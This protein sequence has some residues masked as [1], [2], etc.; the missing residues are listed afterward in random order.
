MK[1]NQTIITVSCL[2][3]TSMVFAQ[4][5]PKVN[6]Y[7]GNST[8]GGD[9]NSQPIIVVSPTPYRSTDY[10]IYPSSK[11]QSEMSIAIS[12]IDPE[13]LLVGANT[14]YS[15]EGNTYYYQGYYYSH[16]G[17]TV[18][19]G[20]D[21][22]PGITSP[23]Y[24][25]AV[26][27]DSNGNVFFHFIT[28]GIGYVKKSTDG[29]VTWQGSIAIP[30][31]G[32][33]DKGHM[34]IDGNNIYVGLTDFAS[35]PG[36][37][38]II[39][40]STD[41]GGTFSNPINISEEITNH[42]SMGVNLA[43]GPNGEVYA[44]WAIGEDW[45]YWVPS[46]HASEGIGFNKSI[47]DG[48]NWQIPNRI[49][50]IDGS[51]NRWFDKNPG[52]QP[53]RTNDFPSIV[54]DRSG[55]ERDGTIYMVWGAKGQ[56]PDRADIFFSKSTNE[57]VS[58]S[59]PV[60]IHDDNTSNDQWF[61]WITVDDLGIIHIVFYDSRNDPNNQL[62]EVWVAQ[63]ID[64]GQSFTNFRV[65]DV[66]FT[67]TPIP[68]TA[69][70]YM[71]DYIGIASRPGKVYT[72]WMDNR[73]GIYQ[74]YVDIIDNTVSGIITENTTW[75]GYKLVTGNVSV[76]D[77]VI[78]TIEPGTSIFFESSTFLIANG[79]LIINGTESNPIVFTSNSAN[80]SVG[81]WQGIIIESGNLEMNY[82]DI[83]YANV[84]VQ[85][86]GA[87][88]GVIQNSHI[89]N[90]NTGIEYVPS[91]FITPNS[92]LSVEN[93]SIS[94]CDVGIHG[95]G[96]NIAIA[97]NYLIGDN[98]TGV[99]IEQS[100]SYKI[101]GNDIV[102]N[103]KAGLVV[104]N[105][106][107]GTIDGNVI[108]GNGN[109]AEWQTDRITGGIFLHASSPTITNNIIQNNKLHGITAMNGSR[110]ILN[111]RERALNQI[112][113]NGDPYDP[114]VFDAEIRWFDQS[115]PHLDYGRNDIMDEDGGYLIYGNYSPFNPVIRVR[116]NYWAE[117]DPTLENRFYP[118]EGYLFRP[119]DTEPNST[120]PNGYFADAP[121]L[122]DQ[123]LL[124]EEDEEWDNAIS[125]YRSIITTYPE[126]KEASSSVIRLYAITKITDGDFQ[127]LQDYY[128]LLLT[129][130]P[131]TLL[132]K[133]AEQYAIL[134][135]VALQDYAIAV[136]KYETILQNPPSLEDS[137]YAVIDIGQVYLASSVAGGN[138]LGRKAAI[139]TMPEY[140]PDDFADYE[141]KVNHASSAMMGKTVVSQSGVLPMD[142]A[143]YSNFPNPFNPITNIKIDIPENS[144]IKLTVFDLSG[145]VV[146]ELMN[147]SIMAGSHHSIW[148]GTNTFNERVSSGMYIVQMK[149][150]S[151][152]AKKHFNNAQKVVLLK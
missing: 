52:G 116:H 64:G 147:Q 53:I 8:E 11:S 132:A 2:L 81:D 36:S 103:H 29:G 80:P 109:E 22:L 145:R 104:R 71:G 47:D 67:P 32:D 91:P 72:S 17:G 39:S 82:C 108:S 135:D 65:S 106:S 55:R 140:Q 89:L 146:T 79:D 111:Y 94:G 114:S 77:G 50:D 115:I 139:G 118:I 34:A 148:N 112:N 51:R 25:P 97:E 75:S 101:T 60:I 150:I 42:F 9:T 69:Y 1:T 12:P 16:E 85:F 19:D 63:S 131:E 129:S 61:P 137:V 84:G 14:V 13:K 38:V 90:C 126:S 70:G 122:F 26:E 18:W 37:P 152:N 117:F 30:G 98:K 113:N 144:H 83:S 96:G 68:W 23:S 123:A 125:A 27:F 41:N 20:G 143:L 48:E 35:F 121:A 73:T 128:T 24:D 31:I 6:P 43:I 142:F 54:V 127:A 57:G 134:C 130:F 110:P 149:A 45:D 133:T 62:T 105:S 15:S 95:F 138:G 28:N 78:L 33:A 124:F 100:R 136:G 120:P 74:A 87:G 59:T 49:F 99:L 44:A 7:Y 5:T 56:A 21:I 107:G 92:S 76:T 141:E 46:T 102:L 3:L 66:A 151:T 88:A 10:G 4:D 119:Y 86:N 93:S 58:W 40:R